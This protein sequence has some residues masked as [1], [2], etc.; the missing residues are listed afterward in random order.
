MFT[1]VESFGWAVWHYILWKCFSQVLYRK[2]GSFQ[3][4]EDDTDDTH[5]RIDT[6]GRAHSMCPDIPYLS[7]CGVLCRLSMTGKLR[8]K[9]SQFDK[10]FLK[11]EEYRSEQEYRIAWE[12]WSICKGQRVMHN[13]LEFMWISS[14]PLRFRWPV[15]LK[16]R[17]SLHRK[18]YSISRRV[19]FRE[20]WRTIK[21]GFNA[22]SS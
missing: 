1:F 22:C 13:C 17:T 11:Q 20:A 18:G 19:A 14:R 10:V 12:D 21:G 2:C 6:R 5:F 7:E 3:G 15:D 9:T 16:K 4:H 8:P